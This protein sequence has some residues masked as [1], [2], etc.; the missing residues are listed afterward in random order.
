MIIFIDLETTGLDVLDRVCSIGIIAVE[1]ENI[2]SIYDVVDEGKKIS[3]EASSVN[4]IT[5][6]MLKGKPKLKD[7]EAFMFL[8]KNNNEDTILIAHNIR[9]DLKMLSL[10]GFEWHG[11]TIDTMRVTKHLI[12]ECEKF[13]LQFLRY[14]LKLYKDEKSEALKCGI[15]DKLEAHNA[16]S[17]A[18]HVKLLYEYLLEIKTVEELIELSSKNVLIEK[19]EFG[20]YSGRYIEDI[21][22]SDRGYL[23][24]ML[25]TMSDLDED[26]SYS[27]R[28]YL[29]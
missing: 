7:S 25:S 2:T 14:E 12:P 6:D 17:D 4:H 28:K 19:L 21:S 3:S 8:Q 15:E 13:S 5:N 29:Y 20:K 23:E 22:M 9:F 27:I 16:I 11:K 24:W 26:L 1:S 10:S 18:L